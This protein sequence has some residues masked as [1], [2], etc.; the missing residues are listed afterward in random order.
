[1]TG[2]LRAPRGLGVVEEFER[3]RRLAPSWPGPEGQRARPLHPER[4]APPE[5]A[6]PGPLGAH[7]GAPA[8]RP[9]RARGAGRRRLPRDQRGRA[10]DELLR[11]PRGP[12]PLRRHL[13]P[14]RRARGGPLPALH[15]PLLRQLQGPR[16]GPAPLRARCSPRSSRQRW[17]RST[18]RWPAASSPS[19]RSSAR[20]PAVKDVAVGIVDVK[21]YCIEPVEEIADRV[22]ALP[23]SRPRR[24]ALLRARLRP[25]PDRALGRAGQARQHGRGRAVG[26]GPSW[27]CGDRARSRPTTPSS[28]TWPG[29]RARAAAAS[30]SGGSARAAS[31]S[32]GNGRHLL[33]DPYL[34]DSLTKKYAAT[35]KPHV[36]M[37]R[38]R[39][40]PRAAR[41]RRRR[42]PRATTT[43]TTSTARPSARCGPRTPASRSSSPRPIAPSWPSAWAAIPRGPVGPRRRPGDRGRPASASPPSPPPTR[44]S[45]ATRADAATISATSCASERGRSTTPATA[46]PTRDRPSACARSPW[47]WP[48][49]PSTAALPSAASPA[50]SRGPR[51]PARPRHRRPPRRA[52]PLRHVRVQHRVAR[53]LRGRVRAARPALPRPPRG[54]APHRGRSAPPR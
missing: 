32:S 13:Q 16:R 9:R 26:C 5:R 3:L 36:R 50:T 23:P 11:A 43:P 47:T 37:T 44:R 18:S 34:S 51:P 15:A 46:S 19:S 54:R 22:R 49:C 40:R 4:P 10:V 1:M 2:E 33:L 7:R 17:T 52:L 38:A 29:P 27:A 45:S 42:R 12:A 24:A 28:P 39:R 30:A 8:H 48:C 31:S 25:E 41:L 53:R 14:H 6:L 20:S 21:S 35:D